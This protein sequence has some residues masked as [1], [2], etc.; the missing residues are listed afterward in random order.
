MENAEVVP[1]LSNIA[2]YYYTEQQTFALAYYLLDDD[3]FPWPWTNKTRPAKTW[4]EVAMIVMRN[5]VMDTDGNTMIL[6]RAMEESNRQAADVFR[7]ELTLSEYIEFAKSVQL[8]EQQFA[9]RA[10]FSLNFE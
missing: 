5:W 7:E 6:L 8:S 9:W 2:L 10:L 3:N 1:L 4:S